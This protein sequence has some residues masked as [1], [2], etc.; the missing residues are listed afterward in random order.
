MSYQI[1]ELT[2]DSLDHPLGID[3]PAPLFAWKFES[4]K[5]MQQS[6]AQLKVG[7]RSG[8]DEMWDSGRMETDCS[9]GIQY[10]G[11]PLIP[12]TR[13][14]VSL[15]TWDQDGRRQT[16]ESWF[17]TGLMNSKQEAWEGAA[18]I[19]SPEY[20]LASDMLSVFRIE[21]TLR[22]LE[23]DKA[24][25]VFGAKDPRLLSSYR[26][27][28]H[29]E[30][31]NYIRYVLNI[32]A[33]PASIE[34]YRV[35][36]SS[37][38]RSDVPFA[39]FP[40]ISAESGMPVITGENVH[41]PHTLRIDVT[42]NCAY[43]YLDG[44]CVDREERPWYFGKLYSGR[45]LNPLG[46]KDTT[47]FPR[48]CE[49]GFY[50]G[51][52][53]LAHFD[54]L[55]VY[56]LRKPQAQVAEWHTEGIT[57]QG[58]TQLLYD[59]SLYGLPMLRTEFTVSKKV[60]QARLYA[61]A[62]GI[63]ECYINGERIGN[64]YFNP[65]ASQFDK[66]LMYQTYD[67]T[68][69]LR[70]GCN[71]LGCILASGW[72][73]EAQTYSLEN[74]NFWGDRMA[75]LGKLTVEYEDGERLTVTTSPDTWQYQR[76]GPYLYASFF[77]GEQYDA[78]KESLL[79]SFFQPG[80]RADNCKR[81]EIIEPVAI[82]TDDQE[83]PVPWATV[84]ETEPELVGH[85]Q[86]PVRPVQVIKAKKMTEPA[87]GVYI[88]DLGQ[89]IAGVPRLKIQGKAESRV[90]IRYGE[91]L[92]PALPEYGDLAGHL[93]QANLREASN[94][95]VYI[96]SGHD[97]EV[98]SPR[99]T[100]HGFRYIEI[101]GVDRAPALE[102]VEGILLSSLTGLTG[103]FICSDKL[104]NQ[105][106]S[107]VGYSQLCNFISIPTDCPQ[108]NERMGWAGDT[109]V[110]CHTALYQSDA[111]NFYWRNLQAMQDLQLPNGRLPNIAPVG[112]GFGGITYESAMVIMVWEL[113]QHY[114]DDRIV[115]SFYPCMKQWMDAME[116]AGFPG[117]VHEF[118]LGDW[119]APVD[120][121]I[122]LI[123]NAFFYRNCVIMFRCAE[124]LGQKDA[125][126]HFRTLAQK[127]LDDWN[128]SFIG[129]DQMTCSLHGKRCDTQA[130]YAIALD[131]GV[132]KGKTKQ[133]FEK[134]LAR[135]TEESG[136]TV[137]T[138]FFGTG[139]LNPM[140]SEGGY[141]E[142]AFKMIRQTQYPSW[143]YP[144]TQGATTVWERWDSYTRDK[145]FGGR[146]AMNS[147][148]HYSLGSVV[149]WLYEYVLGIKRDEK[150]PGF[151]HFFLEPEIHGF[152]YAEGEI[153]TPSGKIVS[154]WKRKGKEVEYSCV[155]PPNTRATLLLNGRSIELE[156]GIYSFTERTAS[157]D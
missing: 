7:F 145:G 146:N 18:W 58:E 88:F 64:D 19:G 87:P 75:F 57:V 127:T 24:G 136:F 4:E 40:A 126:M 133:L 32:E 47:T 93:L 101:S 125:E 143:L 83:A 137:Q 15:I 23:G 63:Y 113:Y 22:I 100:F 35:G 139:S 102:N 38:D 116:T 119:L 3:D 43:T 120:T 54:G 26:N 104:V 151:H 155:V 29:L 51:S 46:S 85:Y 62:R 73:C 97:D 99:F 112:G 1:C 16:A 128:A 31:D 45:T 123:W 27:E 28:S 52:H 96:C 39:S 134:H 129:E 90:I 114:G 72:W 8:G 80:Y 70:N 148:N 21:S 5:P 98:Y 34:I 157:H 55:R 94:T 30:G 150:H 33:Q 118:G 76:K 121:D 60:K 12:S 153:D 41:K 89:E 74:Y 9:I 48:L 105:L 56:H 17:E 130:S 37:E 92:Y 6:A 135:K 77:N 144:V 79:R 81:P 13:Y 69:L 108:R 66:H 91:M 156:S 115:H 138:G 111:K 110:F 152:E 68:A 141:S 25:I 42:G 106:V 14:V 109:H 78:R 53:C 20:V 107:N 149:S 95:D 82:E 65:G 71:A 132:V 61:T 154:R 50:A 10:D 2:V 103:K 124:L 84:N 67:V 142:Q 44:I 59:P 11:K 147:F 86:A 140:L 122:S 36:Y 131:C 49:I 117:E